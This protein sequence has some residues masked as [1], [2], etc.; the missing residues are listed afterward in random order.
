MGYPAAV[1]V[2]RA[3][4]CDTNKLSGVDPAAPALT[5]LVDVALARASIA[6]KVAASLM[7]MYPGQL[8]RALHGEGAMALQRLEAL[9]DGFWRE[10]VSLLAQRYGLE[11]R[12]VDQRDVALNRLIGAFTEFVALAHDGR[13]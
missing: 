3:E 9:P 4:R 13:R 11:V 5:D 10:F 2:D 8:S 12:A 1:F 6:Q 7:R